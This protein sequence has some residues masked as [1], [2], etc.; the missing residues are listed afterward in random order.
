V[1]GDGNAHARPSTR[2]GV[3]VALQAAHSAGSMT[4]AGLLVVA[5]L[6]ARSPWKEWRPE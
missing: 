2:F 6:L 1:R 5:L 4:A 3:L